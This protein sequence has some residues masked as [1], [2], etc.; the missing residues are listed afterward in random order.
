MNIPESEFRKLSPVTRG[1]FLK[2]NDFMHRNVQ[3][4][5]ADIE[6]HSMGHCERVLLFAVLVGEK[7]FGDDQNA[8]EAL[9]QAAV[10]HDTRR[11]DDYLDTGHGAR[12]AVYYEQYCNEHPDIKFHPETVY[13]MRYHDLDDS[14]GVKAIR[15]AFGKDS[16]RVVKLYEIFKDADALDRWRLGSKGLDPKFLRTSPAKGMTEYS[17]R[18]VRAAVPADQLEK[19]EHEVDRIIQQQKNNPN[20]PK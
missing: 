12:A 5:R 16:D 15:K 13:M 11:Q 18:I 20:Q 9:A 7:I 14:K 4:N 2:W 17:H 6:I 3:F 10:S 1:L 19:I 8:L